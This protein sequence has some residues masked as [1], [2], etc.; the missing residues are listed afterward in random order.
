MVTIALNKPG[1]F[2]HKIDFPSKWDELTTEEMELVSVEILAARE[3]GFVKKAYIFTGLIEIRARMQGIKLPA[4][5]KSNLNYEDAASAGFDAIEFLFDSNNR[6][7]NPYPTLKVHFKSL[8]LTGPADDF[9]TLTCGEY[10]DAE[11]Y[12]MQFA[13]SADTQHILGLI[14]VMWR[15]AGTE[16]NADL[17]QKTLKKLSKLP[18]Q[19]QFSIFIWYNGCRSRL[20]KLFPLV[21]GAPSA[22]GSP[23]PAAFTKC[24][25]AG[26]GDRNG[27]R[28]MI[29]KMKLKEF[30]FDMQL[31]AEQVEEMKRNEPK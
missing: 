22:N 6:S 7:I 21:F 24:I 14:S 26:A 15:P 9:N 8:T 18:I 10:E 25:H 4:D 13:N 12:F 11:F 29:R 3:N 19:Q 2:S 5:W 28:D 17:T 27:T 31:Q 1:R 23:D 20:A 30:L 16:Y